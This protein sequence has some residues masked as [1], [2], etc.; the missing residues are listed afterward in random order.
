MKQAKAALSVA[1]T[2]VVRLMPP[3]FHE[4]D[5]KKYNKYYLVY[6]NHNRDATTIMASDY[7]IALDHCSKY[8]DR[9]ATVDIYGEDE[10]EVLVLVAECISP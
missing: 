9:Y 4:Y 2:D 7:D 5:N 3:R 1:K 6:T 10:S 8:A